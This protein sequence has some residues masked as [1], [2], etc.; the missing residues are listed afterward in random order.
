MNNIENRTRRSWRNLRDDKQ[1][2]IALFVALSVP[3]LVGSTAFAI[4]FTN[5]RLVSSR[6]Q[7]AADAGALAGV[8]ALDN[9]S[10]TVSE[11]IKFVD[12]NVPASFGK[13]TLNSDVTIGTYSTAKGFVAGAG[14]TANAVRVVTAR[15]PERGN[16][17][18]RIMSVFWGPDEISLEAQAI[19][20]RQ[21][22]VQ[23]EPPERMLLDNEAW[24][25]NEIYAYCY[26]NLTKTRV[27]GTE[28]LV[29]NNIRL[30][31]DKYTGE[32]VTYNGKT[33][34]KGD[35]IKNATDIITISKGKINKVASDPLVWPECKKQGQA[36]SFRLRNIREVKQYPAKW[37]TA[38]QYNYYTDTVISGGVESFPGLTQAMLENVRCDSLD[39]CDPSKSGSTVPKGKNRTPTKETQPCLPG[40]FMYFGWEDRPPSGGSDKDYDDITMVMKCPKEGILGDGKTRL[41]G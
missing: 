12:L 40:K 15:T 8:K 29:G 34:K 19:A 23:Y 2:V 11:A 27:A 14:A 25:Y 20:A 16:A 18:K 4:D 37:S 13:M 36:L 39:K 26:D 24:D 5:Y 17:A 1:G 6:M 35:T 32:T 22:N 28:T 9:P 3:I 30:G 31:V 41:V 7:A 21:L 33:I 38:A 10:S